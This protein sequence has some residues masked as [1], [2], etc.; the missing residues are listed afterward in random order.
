MYI[1]FDFSKIQDVLPM[2]E[3]LSR[4]KGTSCGILKC[5]GICCLGMVTNEHTSKIQFKWASNRA[6]E[7][8]PIYRKVSFEE[9]WTVLNDI[10]PRKTIGSVTF[11]DGI[12]EYEGNTISMGEAKKLVD[13][14]VTLILNAHAHFSFN[15]GEFKFECLTF[16]TEEMLE[17][18]F[19]LDNYVHDTQVEE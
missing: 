16:T 14:A 15:A 1:Y 17:L 2:I 18:K 12:L 8:N 19:A 5:H 9:F 11:G 10:E 3:K 4:S 7:N 13:A 6:F